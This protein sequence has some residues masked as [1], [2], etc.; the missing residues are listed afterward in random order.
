MQNKIV[1]FNNARYSEAAYTYFKYKQIK[2]IF[3]T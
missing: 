1:S 3:V 2:F